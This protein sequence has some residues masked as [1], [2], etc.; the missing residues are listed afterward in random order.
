MA[1]Y[2]CRSFRINLAASFSFFAALFIFTFYNLWLEDIIVK[3]NT[4]K[5]S[6]TNI[7]PF[8]IHEKNSKDLKKILYYTP[9]FSRRDYSFGYGTKPFSKNHCAFTNCIT[10]NNR[11]LLG[12]LALHIAS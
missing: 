5:Y 1:K 12:K 7:N 8:A 3:F 6:Q 10:T 11:H 4:N 2:Y 9:F